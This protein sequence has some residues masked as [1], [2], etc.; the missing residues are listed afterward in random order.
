M[1][2]PSRFVNCTFENFVPKN[3]KQKKAHDEIWI[4]NKGYGDY[5]IVGPYGSGKTHLL[6]AQYRIYA[7]NPVP[8]NDN[9]VRSTKDLITELQ[10]HEL[11]KKASAILDSL[12]HKK[13]VKLFW[14]D[15]DKF[16]ITEYKLE[17]LFDLVDKIYKSE[18]N[19]TITSN[20]NLVELQEKLSPAITRRI[21]DICQVVE[22]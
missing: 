20:C 14:D 4:T 11:G 19:L 18:S 3:D 6:Y 16:K 2:I 1:S 22:L 21:D 8:G 13:A 7:L 9:F 17:S 12:E 10:L 5:F 15:A